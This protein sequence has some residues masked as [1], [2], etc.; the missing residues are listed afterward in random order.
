MR[1]RRKSPSGRARL[2]A[3]IDKPVLGARDARIAAIAGSAGLHA[4]AVL[5]VMQTDWSRLPDLPMRPLQAFVLREPWP[6]LEPAFESAVE[7]APQPA[8]PSDADEDEQAVAPEA[9]PETESGPQVAE[10]PADD[11]V[12]GIED[13]A[14]DI[15]WEARIPE[16]VVYLRREAERERRYRGF[17]YPAYPQTLPESSSSVP[18]VPTGRP[19]PSRDVPLATTPQAE[20]GLSFAGSCYT[21][22]HH[23]A[24]T[25]GNMYRLTS[26]GVYCRGRTR[27]AEVRDDLFEDI[28]PDYLR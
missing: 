13:E 17:G 26:A 6:P 9:P 11:E 27:P 21:A 23:P 14:P 15:D 20:G 28:K 2:Q 4:L 7:P 25:L 22:D 10:L 1:I 19:P 3:I 24:S 12:S 16:A 8:P 18:S 5:V